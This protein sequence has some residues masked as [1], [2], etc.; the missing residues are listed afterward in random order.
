MVLFGFFLSL[1]AAEGK[2]AHVLP[3]RDPASLVPTVDEFLPP[4]PDIKADGR[5][6]F[7]TVKGKQGVEITFSL[8]PGTMSG[9]VMDWWCVV[10]RNDIAGGTLAPM[11]I[12]PIG[13]YPLV[14][15]PET[16]VCDLSLDPGIYVCMFVLDPTP[17]TKFEMTWYDY[18]V[19]RWE[20]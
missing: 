13:R 3:G 10:F 16:H 5:D 7:V 20:S 8:D 6:D 19:I 1:G 4:S 17:D 15:M 12:T 11:A 2:P 14:D 18:V 9:E